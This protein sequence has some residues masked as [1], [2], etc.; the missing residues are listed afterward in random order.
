MSHDESDAGE[1]QREWPGILICTQCR[2][3]VDAD[4]DAEEAACEHSWDEARD[5]SG[6]DDETWAKIRHDVYVR[7]LDR[8][9]PRNR[10]MVLSELTSLMYDLVMADVLPEDYADREGLEKLLVTDP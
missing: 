10:Q 5:I 7:E 4:M 8:E 1:A 3:Y 9:D 2:R 6:L